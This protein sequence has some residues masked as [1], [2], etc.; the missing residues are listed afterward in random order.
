MKKTIRA[1]ISENG[2][3]LPSIGALC[4]DANTDTVYRVT[5]WDGS[6]QISTNGPGRGNSVD[7]IVAEIGAASDVSEEEWDEIESSNYSVCAA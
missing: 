4:Y 1:T 3:G 5:A 2:N 6:D 7:V